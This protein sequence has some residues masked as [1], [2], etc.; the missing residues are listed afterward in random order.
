[1]VSDFWLLK[2]NLKNGVFGRSKCTCVCLW[3][4]MWSQAIF[5]DFLHGNTVYRGFLMRKTRIWR[6]F[7]CTTSRNMN[8]RRSSV[9]EKPD[10][11]KK[12]P[13]FLYKTSFWTRFFATSSESSSCWTFLRVHLFAY[14]FWSHINW[15][16]SE[17][18]EK[19]P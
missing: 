10:F 15:R 6:Y 19:W 14:D 4:K 2:K 7:L 3:D 13:N 8:F 17:N 18:S 12:M 9:F 1:M 16:F 11:L 5:V